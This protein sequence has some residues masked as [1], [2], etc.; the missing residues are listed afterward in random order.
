MNVE[1]VLY[2]LGSGVRL[3]QP[4]SQGFSFL[5]WVGG[6]RPPTQFKKKKPWERGWRL[7]QYFSCLETDISTHPAVLLDAF[8]AV[9]DIFSFDQAIPMKCFVSH[10]PLFRESGS[11]CREKKRKKRKER[12][13]VKHYTESR[14]LHART[15]RTGV[16]IPLKSRKSF[17]RAT[18]QLLKLRFTA[19]VTFPR[20]LYRPAVHI[21][22]F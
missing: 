12:K 9:S 3:L 10:C 16:R 17:F 2:T 8:M 19:M 15:Q 20:H 21:I 13:V 6:K 1:K 4:R 14:A 18:S 5:N 7:L 22:S 11:V